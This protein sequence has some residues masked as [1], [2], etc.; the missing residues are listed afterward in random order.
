MQSR[1][2]NNIAE[3]LNAASPP[4]LQLQRLTVDPWPRNQ[5]ILTPVTTQ[6]GGNPLPT[7]WG[8]VWSS[9][10]GKK[11]NIRQISKSMSYW[12]FQRSKNMPSFP[13]KLFPSEEESRCLLMEKGMLP[14]C[15][16]SEIMCV[17]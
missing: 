13:S 17:H 10:C 14:C 6:E 1:V 8:T 12:D 5:G 3:F 15:C 7:I 4:P 2:G 9:H 11:L 16:V